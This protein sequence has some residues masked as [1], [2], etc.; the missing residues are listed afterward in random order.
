MVRNPDTWFRTI[1]R[2][3]PSLLR[4]P[5]LLIPDIKAEGACVF[6]SGTCYPH[7]NLYYIISPY[8][9][10][11]ALRTILRSSLARFFV[12]SYGVHMRSNFLRF[13]AQYLRRIPIPAPMG[14][15]EQ[16][17]QEL[18]AL[19]GEQDRDL[20]DRA[21]IQLYSL[22]KCHLELMREAIDP[23]SDELA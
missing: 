12:W 16:V 15:S 22:K 21:V 17:V 5:K 20:I 13:Q 10:L 14:V 8:W 18:V 7:H 1:D 3:Y 9:N 6:D 23:R 2:I 4:T 11:R 19:D